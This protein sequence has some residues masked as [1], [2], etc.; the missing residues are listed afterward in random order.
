LSTKFFEP[1][2]MATAKGK[3]MPQLRQVIFPFPLE[4][5]PEEEVREIAKNLFDEVTSHLVQ[6]PG[7]DT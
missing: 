2:A 6:S 7:S 1:L 3:G 4:T 5:L